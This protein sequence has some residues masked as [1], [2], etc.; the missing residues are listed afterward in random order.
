[1]FSKPEQKVTV[2]NKALGHCCRNCTE[3]LLK[4]Q[5]NLVIWEGWALGY[6]S[7][8]VP[9]FGDFFQMK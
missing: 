1:M 5:K 9:S 7:P 6:D 2:K 8:K 3:L 4:D